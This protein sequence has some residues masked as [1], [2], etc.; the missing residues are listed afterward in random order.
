MT[1]RNLSACMW[2]CDCAHSVLLWATAEFFMKKD[3]HSGCEENFLQQIVGGLK[4]RKSWKQ[5]FLKLHSLKAT[6]FFK[7]S[8]MGQ[9]TVLKVAF[10]RK[11]DFFSN[12]QI[13]R[14]KIFRKTILSL[15]FEFV[16]YYYWRE[17]QISSS[18]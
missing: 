14:R 3:W 13:S 10:F 4:V 16:V 12:L 17:I 1:F 7:A 6:E 2:V 8:E 9:I 18:G 11:C 15:K 5:F